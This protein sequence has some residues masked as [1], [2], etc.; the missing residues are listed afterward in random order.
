[1]SGNYPVELRWV[2]AALALFVTAAIVSMTLPAS[3]GYASCLGSCAIGS[4]RDS[5]TCTARSVECLTRTPRGSQSGSI[6]AIAY[7]VTANKSG[8][9]YGYPTQREAERMA[10]SECLKATNRAN[11]CKPYVWFDNRCGAIASGDDDVVQVGVGTN[12]SAAV[13]AALSSCE[14][15]HGSNCEKIASYCSLR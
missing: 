10:V 12:E 9:S 2:L 7:S 8:H 14:R 11:D 5:P 4:N 15:N 1:M 13:N 3:A 6:G